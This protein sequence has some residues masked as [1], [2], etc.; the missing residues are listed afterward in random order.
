MVKH[1]LTWAL[2]LTEVSP[3]LFIVFINNKRVISRR[4]GKLNIFFIVSLGA[5]TITITITI[6]KLHKFTFYAESEL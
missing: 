3:L 6:T 5:I 4:V 1:H 2:S